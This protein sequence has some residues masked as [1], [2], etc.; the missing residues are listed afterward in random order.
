M[1]EKIRTITEILKI[2]L[3]C[4]CIIAAIILMANAFVN[5]NKENEII[6]VTGLGEIDFD[7]DL[8]VWS[9][10]FTRIEK[11]LQ[12]AYSLL[13]R[14]QQIIIEFMEQHGISGSEVVFDSINIVKEY[15]Q[16]YDQNHNMINKF[17]GFR[18]RQSLKIESTEID[19]TEQISRQI[20]EIINKGVEFYSYQPEYYYTKLAD[21]KIEMIAAA[22]E[23]AHLRAERIAE[24]TGSKLGRLKFSKMGVFQIIARNSNEDYTWAGAYNTS[25]RKKTAVITMR[26]HYGLD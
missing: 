12:K 2:A 4:I 20:T 1:K 19:K 6:D 13:D 24:K 8:I 14:D 21:L 25:S 22:T 3:I 15:E 7:A 26:L 23:D 10:Y 16:I 17:A 18:L 9:G 11:D 5:R